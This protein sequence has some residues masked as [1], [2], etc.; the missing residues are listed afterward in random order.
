MTHRRHLA[1][2]GIAALLLVAAAVARADGA[3]H[4]L[5]LWRVEGA[6]NSV[7]LLGSIHLL[8]ESDYPLPPVIDSAYDDAESLFMELDMDDLDPLAAQGIATELGVL[9]NG[10]SLEALLGSGPYRR[11]AELAER[12]DIPLAL[13]GSTEPW[14]AAINVEQLML[15]RIGFDPAHGIETRFT[16]RAKT[17]SKAI[18]GLESVRQQLEILDGLPME[19]QRALLLQT[20]EDSLELEA[21]M[22]ELVRAW[23]TGDTGLLEQTMLRDMQEHPRLYEQLVVARNRNW[24]QRIVELLKADEDVLVIV[25]ALHLVGPDGLPALLEARGYRPAQM[26]QP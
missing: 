4:D 5:M 18:T 1:R 14:L 25:G 17:D 19:V 3:P 15:M 6:A 10:G 21:R 2:S 11:A 7:Y 20:L 9:S 23:R 24:T 26:S 13:L 16:R 12:A 22:D 8:R